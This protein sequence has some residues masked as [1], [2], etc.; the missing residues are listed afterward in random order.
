MN[1]LNKP[2]NLAEINKS[3]KVDDPTVLLECL[4]C[5]ERLEIEK[6]S[7][8]YLTHLLTM[9]RLLITEVDKIGD[10]QRYIEYWRER[11]K[12][13]TLDDICF[14]INTNSDKR[15][16]SLSPFFFI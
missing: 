16:P 9:H 15:D 14:K 2:L 3:D 6:D 10:I 7:K 1:N 13:I 8:P 4:L 5:E 12:V 11:L